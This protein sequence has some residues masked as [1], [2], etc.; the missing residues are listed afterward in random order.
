[1]ATP[2]TPYRLTAEEEATIDRWFA[3][4]DDGNRYPMVPGSPGSD[5]DWEPP[6]IIAG[7]DFRP[8]RRRRWSAFCRT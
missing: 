7:I 2:D 6:Q 5:F 4:L 1:M 8:R 3:Q